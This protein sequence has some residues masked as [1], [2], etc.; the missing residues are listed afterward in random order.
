MA[1]ILASLVAGLTSGCAARADTYCSDVY[2][3]YLR[4]ADAEVLHEEEAAAAQADGPGLG[5]LED[6]ET[7]AIVA[8]AARLQLVLDNGRCF[9][10]GD[11]SRARAQLAVVQEQ[12]GP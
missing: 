11:V 4:Q 3:E 1:L 9:P 2:S 7:A 8:R 10:P 5:W 6:Q 12:Q